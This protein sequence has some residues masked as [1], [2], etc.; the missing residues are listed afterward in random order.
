[1]LLYKLTELESVIQNSERPNFD[2]L[3]TA[4]TLKNLLLQI[5]FKAE[6]ISEFSFEKMVNLLSHIKGESLSTEEAGLIK[7]IL[8]TI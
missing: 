6:H 8:N 3:N 5:D 4:V 1:M 2:E 7:V